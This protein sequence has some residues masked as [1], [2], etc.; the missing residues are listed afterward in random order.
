MANRR[1]PA[2]DIL[3]QAEKLGLMD[4]LKRLIQQG[5]KL[6]DIDVDTLRRAARDGDASD[7]PDLGRHGNDVLSP[8]GSPVHPNV[9]PYVQGGPT[10]GVFEAGGQQVPLRSQVEGPGQWFHEGDNFPGGPG[11]GRTFSTTHVEGHAAAIMRQEGIMDADV[12]INRDTGP[13]ESA[14]ACRYVLHKLIPEGSTMRV[15]FPD[16]SGTGVRT[17]TFTGGVPRW[18]E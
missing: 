5:K 1:V 6:D 4:L 3:A 18:T 11:S 7:L 10:R 12:F 8:N 15:H 14:G 17:W 13:C 9:P 2:D 16:A